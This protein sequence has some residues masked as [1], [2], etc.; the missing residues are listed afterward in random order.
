M[1]INK[2]FLSLLNNLKLTNYNKDKYVLFFSRH[3]VNSTIRQSIF[4]KCYNKINQSKIIVILEKPGDQSDIIYKS[5]GVNRILYVSKFIKKKKY[6]IFLLAKIFFEFFPEIIK[7]FFSKKY[8]EKFIT[9][10]S[11]EGILFGDLIY[12]TFIRKDHK[13]YNLKKINYIYNFLK[14]YSIIRFKIELIKNVDQNFNINKIISSSKGFISSGN[15]AVRYFSYINKKPIIFASHSYKIY[16]KKNLFASYYHIELDEINSLMDKK[17]RDKVFKYF[18]N[19]FKNLKVTDQ[20]FA[21]KHVFLERYKHKKTQNKFFYN[22]KKLAIIALNCFSDSPHYQGKLLFRDYYDWFVKTINYINDNNIKNTHWLL[23]IHPGQKNTNSMSYNEIPYID[24]I[25][26]LNKIK[27]LE[28]VPEAVGN[29]ELFENSDNCITCVSTIGLEY[30]CFGKKPI[31]CGDNMYSG[32]GIANQITD[33][34]KYFNLLKNMPS[35]NLLSKK[36]IQIA[37]TAVYLLDNIKLNKLEVKKS[38]IPQRYRNGDA[39]NDKQYISEFYSKFKSKKRNITNDEYF[40][41]VFNFV[42]KIS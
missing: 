33:Q 38:I 27:N 28:L 39:L 1:K 5:L 36:Q 13:Y 22:K 10:F 6:N 2:K 19:K 37:K 17:S 9:N 31:I 8:L 15:L 35:K 42:K 34:K 41:K 29:R 14:I 18:N 4:A 24:E 16:S 32:L 3:D 7:L 26:K 25:L 12:D 23:K 30:A 21:A 11:F 20:S 40:K